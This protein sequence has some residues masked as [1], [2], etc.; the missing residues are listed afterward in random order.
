MTAGGAEDEVEEEPLPDEPPVLAGVA[1]PVLAAPAEACS[2][3]I[4]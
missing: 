2:G 3:G 1:A 4:T